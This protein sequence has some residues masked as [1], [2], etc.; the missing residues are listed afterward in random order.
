[1]GGVGHSIAVSVRHA[2]LGVLIALAP[3]LRGH[4]QD[5]P[6]APPAPAE[7]Q[8]LGGSELESTLVYDADP[9]HPHLLRASCAG[10]EHARLWLGSKE[11]ESAT[12]LLRLRSGERLFGLLLA[13]G[14]AVELQGAERDEAL[15]QFEMRRAL[16][17][18]DEM[19]WKG[20]GPTR[21]VAIENL[22]RLEAR[23]ASAGDARPVR[24]DFSDAKGVAGDGFRELAWKTVEGRSEP[25]SLEFWHAGQRVWKET[26][27]RIQPKTFARSLFLPRELREGAPAAVQWKVVPS[28]AP[29]H[30]A[31]RFE[32]PAGASFERAKLEL[33]RLREEWSPKLAAL[34][35]KLEERGTLELDEALR[36]RWVVLRLAAVPDSLPEGFERISGRSAAGTLVDGFDRL[37]PAALEALRA[38]VPAAA[39][40]GKP[41]VRWSLAPG[42]E[43]Q[44]F[45]LLAWSGAH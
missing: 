11:D 28:P 42:G 27:E 21:T 6:P 33:A 12:R 17:C 7:P 44:L 24:I 31:R 1:M 29:E 20:D 3:L 36:P 23:F 43:H 9:K 14:D 16:L 13:S 18:F 45:L 26:V 34:G 10:R 22:G 37:S 39:S 32:L 4:A 5:K 19:G 2:A 35:L 15:V 38:K 8:L 40:P 30:A 25:R 41:Y